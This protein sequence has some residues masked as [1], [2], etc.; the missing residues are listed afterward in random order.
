[1]ARP[2]PV[3]APVTTATFPESMFG[4]KHCI[5]PGGDMPAVLYD[6][7][8]DEV[9]VLCG[10]GPAPRA[11]TIDAFRE[12][13]VDLIPGTGLLPAVVPGAFGA[14]LLMLERFGT[15]RFADVVEFA[16]GFA[17]SGFPVIPSITRVIGQVEEV[18][19]N[20]WPSSAEVY[21]SAA[22]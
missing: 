12:R 22:A 2:S 11:A 16:I 5:G 4:A 15:W 17:E 21:C 20:E 3:P 7:K 9:L 8:R 1:M 13:G 6:A 10:Q 19:R 18:F 14:W